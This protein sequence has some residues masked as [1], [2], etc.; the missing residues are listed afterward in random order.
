[1]VRTLEGKR[2]EYYEAVLQ[3]RDC[4]QEAVGVVKEKIAREGIP[5]AKVLEVA[6]GWDFYLADK[7]FTKA[8]GK[9]IQ[10]RFGGDYKVT[11]SLWGRKEG[12]EVHRLTVLVRGIG[13][14]KG[15]IVE[16]KGEDYEVK[17]LLE[18]EIMLQK[19]KTGEKVHVKYKKMEKIRKKEI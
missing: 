11:A 5:V 18:K 17:L 6:G 15:E 1:M 19:V 10:E 13:F 14:K 16:Y 3:L 8:L 4:G 9:K 12:K 2:P 7:N